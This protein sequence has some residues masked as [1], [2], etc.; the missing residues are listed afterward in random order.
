MTDTGNT[1]DLVELTS[2]LG[3]PAHEQGA[4]LAWTNELPERLWTEAEVEDLIG[5][6]NADTARIDRERG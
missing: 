1:T 2:R 6:W 5:I 3:L 4:V